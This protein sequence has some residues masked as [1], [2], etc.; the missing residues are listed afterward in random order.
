MMHISNKQNIPLSAQKLKQ[1][2]GILHCQPEDITEIEVLKKGMTN[3]SFLFSCRGEQMIFRIP[4]KGTDCL[5]NR[6]QEA[7]VYQKIAGLGLCD[8]VVYIDA[9]TGYKITRYLKNVRSCHPENEADVRLCMKKLHALHDMRL[10]VAHSF[11]IF[12]QIAYYESLWNGMPSVYADYL[13]TKASVFSLMPYIRKHSKEWCLAHIDAVPDNFLFTTNDDGTEQLQLTDW[14]Y[15][16][17][18]DPDIDLAM[19]CIY[20]GYDRSR[21]DALID[22]YFDGTCEDSIRIK[23]YAYVAACGLL[24]SNWCEYKSQ[25]GIEFGEYACRQ[26]AYA[27][28]YSAFVR[29][30]LDNA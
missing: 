22:I 10:E 24:W 30:L 2:A 25:L 27:K 11:D 29:R 7:A 28:E 9:A 17:M 14:E 12:Q 6:F 18:Q 19:F 5:I 8:D 20:S 3:Q 21:I 15:A 4:G 16:G 23:I 26:Y 13:Q 1:L